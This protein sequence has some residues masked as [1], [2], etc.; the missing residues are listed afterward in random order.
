MTHLL[1]ELQNTD[2][3]ESIHEIQFSLFS[4]QDIKRGSVAD[5]LTPETYDANIPKNNGLFDH[6]MGSID[7]AIICPTD[8]KKAELC[9]GY[10]GKI[11][12]ALP[13]FNN[14]FIPYVEKV[15]KCV[16]FRCSNLLIDKT[17]PAV[18]KELEGKKGYNRF[19]TILGLSIKNKKC[20]YNNGCYVLQ[21]TKYTKLNVTS[22][23]EK[24]NIVKIY[25]EF[26]QNSLKDSKVLNQQV[27]TPL[28]CYQIFKK[29]KDEDVDF[30]GFSSKYSRPE[31]MLIT[32]LAV[33][34]PSVRPS[35]RQSDNQRSED[36][37][38]YALCNIVKV[39]KTLKQV[40]E[41]GN[42]KKIDDYQGYLQYL[43][44]TYMDNE[45]PGVPPNAQRSSFRP[46]KAITQRLKG[47]E[48]RI[49][50]NI[51]GKRV[52]Y[53]ARTVISVDPNIDIDEYGV[54]Q[55]IA[56]NLTFPEIVTKFNIK[57]LRKTVRN[58]PKKYP[59]AKTVTKVEGAVNKNISLKHVDVNQVAD[60]LQIGDIV[61]RHLLDGDVCLFNRQPTLHRMS[62]MTH[63]IKILPFNTFRLNVSV[64]KPYNA[65]FDGDEM[66]MHI[67]Q[68]LQTFT[69]LE[70]ICLVPNHIISPGT[71]KPCIEITQ[72]T[73]VGA[74][75]LTIQDIR[76]TKDKMYNYMM[77]SKKYDGQLPEP[78]GIDNGVP[79]WTGKQL[80]SLIIPDININQS[81]KVKVIRGEITSGFLNSD[82]LGN[83]P[84]GLIKQ[85]FNAYGTDKCVDFL[86][87]TQKL[88]TRWTMDNSFTIGLGDAVVQKENRAVIKELMN[89]YLEETFDLIRKAQHG[90][91][92]NDLDDAYKYSKLEY[93]MSQILSKLTEKVKDYLYEIM[94]KT[95][96]FYIAG[97]KASGSKGKAI[98]VQQVMGLVGQQDIWGSRIDDGFTERTLPHFSRNDIGPDAKGFCRNSYVEGLSPSEMFFHSMGGRTGTIDTAIRTA[99]SGYTSRKFIKAAEDL[100]VNYD[101]TVRNATGNIIQFAYGDDNF[102]PI[103]LE[104][105]TKIELAE[106]DLKQMENKYKFEE[107][108]DREYFEL[109]MTRAAFE[110][111]IENKDY[112]NLLNDEY[113]TMCENQNELRHN[114]FKNA[115]NIGDIGTYI[116]IN[117]Y[118][119]IPSQ[120]IK[121]GI[122][123]FHLCDMTP[124]YILDTY[125]DAMIDMVKYLPERAQNWKLFKIIFKSFLSVKR[126]MKEF[127]LNKMAFDSIILMIKEKMMEAIIHP[128]EMVGIIG[129]QTL[130]EISTQLTLNS[131]TYETEIIV[132]DENKKIKK[133]QIGDF[134]EK[135]IRLSEK[136]EYMQDKDTTYAECSKYYEIPSC[137]EDGNVWWKRIEAVTRHPVINEDGS[138][139]ML[140]ITTCEEREVI[141]TKAKSLLKLVNGKIIPVEG[142]SVKVDDYLPVSLKEIDFEES[143]S[144]NLKTILPPNEYVYGSELEKAKSVMKEHHWWMNH[145]NKTFV[146]PHRR[147]DTVVQLASDRIRP[148][149]S[150]KSTIKD[151][152]V[153][154]LSS[155]LCDYNI[156]ET[157]ELDYNFGYLIGA[158]CAEGCMTLHQL[159]IANNDAEYFKP[160]E[161]LCAKWN[162]TT[163]VYRHENK[164]QEGWT[165][166][167]LRIYNTILCRI[168]EKFCGKLSHNKFVSDEI[169]FSNKTCLRGFLDAY[170]GGD[171]YVDEKRKYI[172]VSSVSKKMLIDVQQILNIFGVY[173]KIKKYKKQESNNRGSQDIKQLYHLFVTNQQAQKLAKILKMKVDPKQAKLTEIL[174]HDYKLKY[175][176]NYLQVP[177]EID[178]TIVMEDRDNKYLGVIFDKIKSIEEV[179]NTTSYAFDLTI[180][181]TRNFNVYNGFCILDTFHQA[182]VGAGSLVI[183]EGI[184]RLR[185]IINLT[186]NLK[187]KNMTIFL[188]EEY[189]TNKEN[190][191]KIQSKFAYTQLK[192]VLACSEILYDNKNGLTDK[193][194]DREFIKTYKEF[195]K[196][197]DVDD[198]DDECLSPWILR[199]TFDKESLMNRKISIQ[200]IQETIKEKSHNDQDIEC[201]F[202]DDS[203][204]DV[205]LRIRIKS[206]GKE[207]F[208]EFLK[209]I[210][211]QLV[212]LSLR[213]IKDI[214]QVELKE[215][216]ILKYNLDGSVTPKKEWCLE[217]DGSNLLDILA[218][219]AVDITR[220]KTTDIIEFH[221]VY[222]IEATREMIYRELLKVF[223]GS[224]QPNPRHI[225]MLSDIMTYRG[226]LM[227]IDRHGLNKN[228]EIGPI[229]KASFEEVMNIFTKAALFAEKD[230]MKGVSA[231][232]LAGQFCKSGTNCFDILMDEEKLLEKIDIPDYVENNYESVGEKEVEQEFMKAYK[233][234][235]PDE[236]VKDE[237]FEFGFKRAEKEYSLK[238]IIKNAIVLK[239]MENPNVANDNVELEKIVV[240]EPAYEIT[241]EGIQVQNN[242]D[243]EEEE[244]NFGAINLEDPK[245]EEEPKKNIKIIKVK[246]TKT[247]EPKTLEPVVEDK[248]EE[249]KKPG[250]KKKSEE[251]K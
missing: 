238:P 79:Y 180:S 242:S 109:F 37:L 114:Y 93:D 208:M 159:S 77:F 161:E 240:E 183:T 224:S 82:S 231:N 4:H 105:V 136:V 189:S 168:L 8:E 148:G 34:P 90:A 150:R 83:D 174:M 145:A 24:N 181:D 202:S 45:I 249:K 220:I 65:D 147:S 226:K 230:N 162:I 44:S 120:R 11:D 5:I 1:R 107:L 53:S 85:I 200:E 151:G 87:D 142:N 193:G 66:N 3:L 134:I 54:P 19:V 116:P 58:G 236:D 43:V 233:P 218:D 215:K 14:H 247:I 68:S 88:I 153:Y 248:K 26:S 99:D 221:E 39:N 201:I 178:G 164:N 223:A 32:S 243:P 204:N 49:R 40:L 179:S 141:V 239:E 184:P 35:V 234:K 60:N 213:G 157:I 46:L 140:K 113:S 13:V 104:K 27:F 123:D 177:N 163:K 94:P 41:G 17:N 69:E 185:E 117:L 59:G 118:R 175:S 138:N 209:D 232:I 182:G 71:S 219:D 15:L 172:S 50:G 143:G 21:P 129:A 156:P 56:M 25:A 125:N 64:C 80:F 47:K 10:F 28:I 206:D 165:S 251:N 207:N 70:Q 55:K 101:L 100:M 216:N 131:V 137:D 152:F 135:E 57:N 18:L 187:S 52:D 42:N 112:K 62:M 96:N 36:D 246:K 38:T 205:V 149:R 237:D 228:S 86:N 171:G 20:I 89:T 75:L 235:E 211:K 124:Q 132:R 67:P 126:V 139:T 6:N 106:Y 227:Q 173:G 74:Y 195:T 92:A 154:M 63:R 78:A 91:F 108:A 61:H 51:M 133:V 76:L 127:R 121:F 95:N 160:I 158:Y 244:L 2:N 225:Q 7:A 98:N 197:F 22:M 190:A 210:E 199:L 30:L 214:S 33:P 31:W 16:C 170:I 191:R 146:L 97:D 72:D 169:I 194:E 12:M 245:Y 166:Q 9:P 188:K 186:K 81:P 103:K 198:I 23:K 176:K 122:E 155:N 84:S 48:G 196:L 241:D 115:E 102:D 128:G 203:A 192:D 29:I 217:T 73:L 110:E 212:E 222:G 167:D 130:G 250:R 111:M 229:A 144:L 119:V